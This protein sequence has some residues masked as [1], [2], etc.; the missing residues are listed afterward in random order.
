MAKSISELK[1][2]SDVGTIIAFAGHKNPEGYLLCDGSLFNITD[3]FALFNAIGTNYGGSITGTPA[4]LDTLICT[5]ATVVV[6]IN[7]G[8]PF[9]RIS[10]H[11][12]AGSVIMPAVANPNGFTM[13]I[14]GYVFDVD[15]NEVETTTGSL[16]LY[17]QDSNVINESWWNN[18]NPGDEWSPYGGF[19][20]VNDGTTIPNTGWSGTFGVPDLQ[21]DCVL[22]ANA[23]KVTMNAGSHNAVTG[24]NNHDPSV[25]MAVTGNVTLT[26]SG[27][28]SIGNQNAAKPNAT[29]VYSDTTITA[30]MIPRHKHHVLIG[31]RAE[32]RRYL[33]GNAG[34]RSLTHTV[35][36][37][38]GNQANDNFI[39]SAN[40]GSNNNNKHSHPL[41]VNTG[42]NIQPNVSSNTLTG[43][44]VT[45][46]AGSA[47]PSTVSVKNP[48]LTVKYL[49]K[50]I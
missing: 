40:T 31:Y 50:E 18:L 21:G 12:D 6:R 45:Q 25:S 34:N 17:A 48:T 29:G 2:R 42:G 43:N 36:R 4:I 1:D 11:R 14:N 33:Q 26:P 7:T 19:V 27:G 22:A 24:S 49:I 37:R 23:Q 32:S 44:L 13:T 3:K 9:M 15:T 38:S 20:I 30:A 10:L 46:I 41:T 39:A 16:W 28:L 5:T 35:A 47:I 8:T